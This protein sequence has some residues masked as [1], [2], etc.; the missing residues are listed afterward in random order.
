MNR[1]E[2]LNIPEGRELDVLIATTIMKLELWWGDPTGFNI[3]ENFN[4]WRKD[5]VD[6]D[7]EYYALCPYYSTKISAAW[8]VVE[9]L[10][11]TYLIEVGV[12]KGLSSCKI[13]QEVKD[14]WKYEMLVEQIYESAPLAICR[15][16]LLL[17]KK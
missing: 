11:Q 7:G 14:D 17:S 9:N 2:I 15:A 10:S 12:E 4:Y 13:L 3:P 5:Y 1:K 16:V 6:E 8:E